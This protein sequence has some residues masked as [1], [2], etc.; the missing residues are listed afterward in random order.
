C[1]AVDETAPISQGGSMP[2]LLMALTAALSMVLLVCGVA[3]S[4]AGSGVAGPAIPGGD[5]TAVCT[6]TANGSTFTL[7]ADCGPV[8]SPLTVPATITTVDGGGHTVSADDAG[9]PQFNG[10]IVTNAGAGQTMNIQNVTIT[11]PAAGFQLCTN[12]NFVLYGIYFNGAAGGS[13]SN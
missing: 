9:A 3:A 6:G 12:S 5:I 2:R 1:R 13:V 4:A 7:T 11:G 10:G 8:S